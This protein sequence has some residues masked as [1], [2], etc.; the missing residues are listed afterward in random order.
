MKTDLYVPL[1]VLAFLLLASTFLKYKHWQFFSLIIVAI[2]YGFLLS[3]TFWL[4][5]L[6]VEMGLFLSFLFL[7]MIYQSWKFYLN[8]ILKTS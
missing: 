5:K 7:G 6:D 1:A 8:N 3:E 2:A 4:G